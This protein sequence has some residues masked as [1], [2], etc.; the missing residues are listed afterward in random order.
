MLARALALPIGERSL[1]GTLLWNFCHCLLFTNVLIFLFLQHITFVCINASKKL[2]MLMREIY[3]RLII[4]CVS[5][6]ETNIQ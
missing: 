3:H 2:P 4:S 1:V 5:L 6:I